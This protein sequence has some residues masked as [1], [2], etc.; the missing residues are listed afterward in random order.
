M[1]NAARLSL[2][3]VNLQKQYLKSECN[4]KTCLASLAPE[5][6]ERGQWPAYNGGALAQ[7]LEP[8]WGSPGQ[9]EDALGPSS[10]WHGADAADALS[11]L[12]ALHLSLCTSQQDIRHT[13]LALYMTQLCQICSQGHAY[14]LQTWCVKCF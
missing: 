9:C 8:A 12:S 10:T 11:H 4:D 1:L 3:L 13:A 2:V 14:M 7:A 5:E 6:E